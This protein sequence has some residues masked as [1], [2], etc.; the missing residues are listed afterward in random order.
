M[1]PYEI[2]RNKNLYYLYGLEIEEYALMLEAQ[3]GVCKICGSRPEKEPL[4]VDHCHNS[5]EI[6]GL[7]CRD[8]NVGLARFKDNPSLL[9]AAKIYLQSTNNQTP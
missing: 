7:L 1:T 2:N 4:D 5:L 8:C 9:E 6:R 3:G